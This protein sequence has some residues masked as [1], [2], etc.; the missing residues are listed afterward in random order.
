MLCFSSGFLASFLLGEPVIKPFLNHRDLA[1]ATVV[2]YF[3]FFSPF[4]L[5]YKILRWSPIKL[6]ISL[7]KEVQRAHKILDGV[8][9][10]AHLYPDAYFLMVLIGTIKG[11]LFSQSSLSLFNC[12]AGG[13]VAFYKTIA[14]QLVFNVHDHEH[15]SSKLMAMKMPPLEFLNLTLYV[16]VFFFVH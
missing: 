12:R 9:H 3:V 10:V 6:V 8:N 1:T 11:M 7:V 14:Y 13:G 15:R 16:I 5:V 4:D 2:W